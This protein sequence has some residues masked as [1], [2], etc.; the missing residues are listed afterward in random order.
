MSVPI[1]LIIL[2]I[3]GIAGYLLARHVFRP[4]ADRPERDPGTGSSAHEEPGEPSRHM[5]ALAAPD[6]PAAGEAVPGGA[7]GMSAQS[8]APA[9]GA[10]RAAGGPAREEEPVPG[11]GSTWSATASRDPA[12]RRPEMAAGRPRE[13]TSEAIGSGESEAAGGVASAAAPGRLEEEPKPS[14]G[15]A[16]DGRSG[17]LGADDAPPAVAADGPAGTPPAGL[18][19]GERQPDDLQR[20]SGIGP[21]IARTL[22]GLGIHRFEQIAAFTPENIAWVDSHLRFKGRI[23][24]EDWVGQARRLTRDR[25]GS[26]SENH[27]TSQP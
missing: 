24:R 7:P 10:S 25:G 4:Q 3:G 6:D 8:S 19:R 14:A 17:D 21:G 22:N 9:P 2:I 13:A 20:I 27:S 23:D 18:G 12:E 11:P 26:G 1:V 5:S 15:A 16:G